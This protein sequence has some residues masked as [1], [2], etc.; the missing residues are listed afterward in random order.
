MNP[1]LRARRRDRGVYLGGHPLL[2]GLL[3]AT[4]GRPVRRIGG[5]V[6]VHDAEAY[7][8][9]LTRLPL[10]RTAPGTTGGAARAALE[11]AGGVLFDQEGSGHRADRRVLAERLGAAGVAE[12]RALWQPLLVRRLLP[13]ARGGEVDAVELARELAGVVV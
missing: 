5:S 3:A 11:G 8:E 6:L 2:F 1:A 12:L 4:R 7:R 10:D 9:A 13:L